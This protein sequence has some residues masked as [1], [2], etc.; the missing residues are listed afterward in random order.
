LKVELKLV[1]D[2]PPDLKVFCEGNVCLA[3]LFNINIKDR[4]VQSRGIAVPHAA[5]LFCHA[6]KE[7]AE[8]GTHAPGP[9]TR[10]PVSKPTA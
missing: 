1:V 10:M 5:I 9:L 6:T 7:D 2:W 8:K 3:R 4:Q